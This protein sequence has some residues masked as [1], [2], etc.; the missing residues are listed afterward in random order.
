M[1]TAFNAAI[2]SLWECSL[3][4]TSVI[5]VCGTSERLDGVNEKHHVNVVFFFWLG[6][7][8]VVAWKQFYRLPI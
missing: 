6:F 1:Q 5:I 4:V 7:E 8:C 3:P 2:G